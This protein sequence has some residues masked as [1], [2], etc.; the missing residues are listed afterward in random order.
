[1]AFVSVSLH[2]HLSTQLHSGDVSLD[3]SLLVF[4]HPTPLSPGV[5]N[6]FPPLPTPHPLSLPF[7][8]LVCCSPA[9]KD[10]SN[11]R[12]ICIYITHVMSSV[13]L[14]PRSTAWHQHDTHIGNHMPVISSSHPRAHFTR[15]MRGVEQI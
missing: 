14:W 10:E 11:R 5:T 2:L 1:M 12:S 9:M 4:S 7:P 15:N 6:T 13:L 3:F 8:P